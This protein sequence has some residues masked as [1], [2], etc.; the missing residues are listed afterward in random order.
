LILLAAAVCPEDPDGVFVQDDG[1]A[2]GGGLGGLGPDLGV[3]L[4]V[5]A[6][7]VVGLEPVPERGGRAT[8][9]FQS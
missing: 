4:L 2:S 3:R 5:A 7:L 9:A 8:H 6:D 1:A